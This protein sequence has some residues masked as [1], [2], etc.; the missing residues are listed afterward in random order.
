MDL[1]PARQLASDPQKMPDS[2][3][4]AVSLKLW[5]AAHSLPPSGTFAQKSHGTQKNLV[6]SGVENKTSD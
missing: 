2:S 6:T 4:I 5:F 3:L 1:A